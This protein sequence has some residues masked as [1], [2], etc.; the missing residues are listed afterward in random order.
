[1]TVPEL[2]SL[3]EVFPD[4]ITVEEFKSTIP[5]F[6]ENNPCY[7]ETP[8]QMAERMRPMIQRIVDSGEDFFFGGFDDFGD[9]C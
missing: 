8:Q 5:S 9:W 6:V 1:L 4:Y 3:K 2:K 7:S